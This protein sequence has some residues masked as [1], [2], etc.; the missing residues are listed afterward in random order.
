M[1]QVTQILQRLLKNLR[2][3]FYRSR[4]YKNVEAILVLRFIWNH[5]EKWFVLKHLT[6]FV[7][8]NHNCSLKQATVVELWS[9][10]LDR[11]GSYYITKF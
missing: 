4:P 10:K 7:S 11:G 5:K 8:Q 6:Y 3:I 9:K 1:L 2:I